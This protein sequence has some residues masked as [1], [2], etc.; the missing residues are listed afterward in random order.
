MCT[1]EK[2]DSDATES[3][4]WANNPANPFADFPKDPDS[5]KWIL[6]DY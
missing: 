6:P 3:E 2:K 5:W 1:N 4:D